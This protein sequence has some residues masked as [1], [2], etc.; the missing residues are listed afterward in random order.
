M[1][2]PGLKKS[3]LL[4]NIPLNSGVDPPN[5]FAVLLIK[6]RIY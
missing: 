5:L 2:N 6:S 4:I 3:C 1:K